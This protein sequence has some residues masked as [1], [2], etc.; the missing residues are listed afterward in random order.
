MRE[1]DIVV[2]HGDPR[3]LLVRI[4]A[5][6]F[7]C[8]ICVAHAPQHSRPWQERCAWWSSIGQILG[9]FSSNQYPLVL[10]ADM[11]GS[12]G[13]HPCHAIGSLGAESTDE[14]GDAWTALVHDRQLWVPS[15]LAA[16]HVGPTATYVAVRGQSE[17]RND[18]IAWPVEWRDSFNII[19]WVEQDCDIGNKQL[20]HKPAVLRAMWTA[21]KWPHVKGTTKSCDWARGDAQILRNRMASMPHVP[22]TCNVDRHAT[23]ITDRLVSAQQAAFQRKKR[24]PQ[25]SYISYATWK[26]VSQRAEKRRYAKKLDAQAAW[27]TKRSALLRWSRRHD[28]AD[29]A[30]RVL[31]QCL[32]ARAKC[33][34]GHEMLGILLREMLSKDKASYLNRIATACQQAVSGHR[35]YDAF[36]AVRFFRPPGKRVRKGIKAMPQ[37]AL[38]D[39]S[40]APTR[41]DAADRWLQHF[42]AVEG[43]EVVPR[44]LP[45]YF[46]AVEERISDEM[47]KNGTVC[48]A[49]GCVPT[50][51]EWECS[52]RKAKRRKAPGPDQ[53]RAELVRLDVA[54]VAQAT[55]PLVM[56]MSMT[57]RE[58][59]RYKGGLLAAVYKGK[60]SH[61]EC[62]NSRSIML[63]N[64]VSKRYHSCLRDHILPYALDHIEPAQA[65]AVPGRGTE[66]IAMYVRAMQ[67]W[68]RSRGRAAALIFID[69]K[70]AFYSVFRPLLLG[71]DLTD[72]Y[73]AWAMDFMN[74]PSAYMQWLREIVEEGPVVDK[75][76]V[77]SFFQRQLC[78]VLTHAWFGTAASRELAYSWC[79]TRPG[80]PLGDIL[81]VMLCSVVLADVREQYEA[82]DL[83][84]EVPAFDLCGIEAPTCNVP[85]PTWVDDVVSYQEA[86]S[87]HD[88]I[89]RTK[90]ACAVLHNAFGKHGLV[91][92]TSRCKS[93]CMPMIRGHGAQEVRTWQ[94]E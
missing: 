86:Q 19:T 35:P 90:V 21:C 61:A 67:S 25:K 9:K 94:L 8:D 47:D 22:W 36:K 80:D 77:P 37:V 60:G 43:A 68:A 11:N 62:S 44:E 88:L 41:Q 10:L 85:L 72:D 84:V 3:C 57:G 74:I 54:S 87:P 92:N 56:K 66:Y 91:L 50:R 59:L 70:A 51:L 32:R 17:H 1:S 38:D 64:T 24:A 6:S 46:A 5:E 34:H 52:L 83:H 15:T 31:Q 4:C 75:A 26:V 89:R 28:Q 42:A 93:E 81:F 69:V 39:G 48:F 27:S 63:A 82:L 79:G 49:G 13:Q 2:L 53:V 73:L 45:P 7:R 29:K 30:K 76:G 23:A 58:P 14:N 40:L 33:L 18:L 65:G 78:D 12:I 20:D 71:N 55:F 16:H